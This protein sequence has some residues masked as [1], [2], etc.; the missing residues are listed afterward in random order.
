M[1]EPLSELR[2]GSGASLQ[3]ADQLDPST[4]GSAN[5]AAHVTGP[6][7]GNGVS[8]S[9]VNGSSDPRAGY[10]GPRVGARLTSEE[11]KRQID[12]LS[13]EQALIDFERAN[14]R[15]LDLTARLVESQKRVLDVQGEGDQLRAEI[16]ALRDA[17]AAAQARSA[18]ITSSRAYKWSNRMVAIRNALR[19]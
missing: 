13:L 15:V 18:E 4:N 3:A 19:G 12:A 9:V 5:A 1:A 2:A 7:L 8:N 14:A 11:L 10:D 16:A 17:L 6:A